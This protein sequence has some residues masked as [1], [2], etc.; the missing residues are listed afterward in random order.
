MPHPARAG[1]RTCGQ[2]P[3]R[4]SVTGRVYAAE[5]AALSGTLN[6][7]PSSEV[8]R[9]FRQNTPGVAGVPCAPRTRPD[10][11]RSAPAPSRERALVSDPVDAGRRF[12]P[13]L[14]GQCSTSSRSTPPY[15]TEVNSRM[16]RV[17]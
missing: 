3:C 7:V 16:V 8:R 14:S 12:S 11:T 5:F 2:G 17:K 4:A 9:R 15:P 10:S 1:S 13:R 6:V